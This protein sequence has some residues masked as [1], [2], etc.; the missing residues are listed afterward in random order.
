MSHGQSL[1]V[2]WSGMRPY[3]GRLFFEQLP[4]A[5]YLDMVNYVLGVFGA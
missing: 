5:K 4:P 3:M 1:T 2:V